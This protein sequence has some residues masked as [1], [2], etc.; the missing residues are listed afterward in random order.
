MITLN[1]T[2]LSDIETNLF[3]AVFALVNESSKTV[4]ISRTNCLAE[5]IL[6]AVKNIDSGNHKIKSLTNWKLLCLYSGE[7]LLYNYSRISREYKENGFT[8][9]NRQVKYSLRKKL[10]RGDNGKYTSIVTLSTRNYDLKVLGEFKTNQE[11]DEFIKQWLVT[12]SL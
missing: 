1:S 7:N 9:L 5:G 4:W 8:L 2:I 12:N 10:K 6:R 3:P 11:S